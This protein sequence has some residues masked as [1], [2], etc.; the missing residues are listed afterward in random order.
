VT[1]QQRTA[2]QWPCRLAI[3]TLHPRYRRRGAMTSAIVTVN[4]GYE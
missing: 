2:I 1:D 4:T 3:E